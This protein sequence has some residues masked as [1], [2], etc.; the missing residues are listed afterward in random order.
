MAN[1]M[2]KIDSVTVGS[3]G[4]ASIEFTSI[5]GTYT[6][7]MVLCSIRTNRSSTGD[8]IFTSLNGVR[9]TYGR[10]SWVSGTSLYYITQAD[11]ALFPVPSANTAASV[12]S[13]AELYLPSYTRTVA[14]S[15]II[16][17]VAIDTNGSPQGTSTSG[18]LYNS[19]SPASNAI[20]SIT[21]APRFGSLIL[22]HS[23]AYLYGIKNT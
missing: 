7:L 8:Y 2:V 3:G 9:E 11:N 21:F 14:K 12:F 18:F 22:Q 1:T 4:Q 19:G 6:D 5:P 15:M 13:N 23:T 16:N 10:Q 20:T 17:S